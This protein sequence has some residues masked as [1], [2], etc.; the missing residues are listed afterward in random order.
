MPSASH[1]S[2]C[3]LHLIILNGKV[4]KWL[5]ALAAAAAPHP[6][7]VKLPGAAATVGE[8]A[9]APFHRPGSPSKWKTRPKLIGKP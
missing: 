9:A 5:L 7:V 8:K 4:A 1:H 2:Q 6:A 3:H